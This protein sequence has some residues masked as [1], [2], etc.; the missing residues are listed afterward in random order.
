VS[1]D[2][3]YK[4]F[5]FRSSLAV[6]TFVARNCGSAWIF[7]SFLLLDGWL[8]P[9]LAKLPYMILSLPFGLV[10][11]AV[12]ALFVL[13]SSQIEIPD[14]QLRFRRFVAW[15]SVPLDSIVT[16]IRLPGGIYLRLNHAGE[17]YRLIFTSED[18]KMHW[19]GS[20]VIGFL[21]EA[22]KRNEEK[23]ASPA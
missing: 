12:G 9:S 7:F 16:I 14:G 23:R 6:T 2:E 11:L 1:T 19:R 18:F 17:T 5:K 21:Q 8:H 4:E 13:N 20:P 22:C 15:K 10:F 3:T